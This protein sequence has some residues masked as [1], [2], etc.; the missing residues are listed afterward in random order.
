[1][2]RSF[3]G[4]SAE[5]D[6]ALAGEQLAHQIR[7][8]FDGLEP[9]AVVVFASSAHHPQRLLE[10]LRSGI[11]PDAALAGASSAGEF[12]QSQQAEGQVSVLALWSDEMSFSVGVGRQVR[13]SPAAAAGAVA[14]GFRGLRDTYFAYKTAMV[15]TDA[16]AGYADEVVE[17][18]T[19]ATAGGY[20]FFGG[21]A[22]D[23]GKFHQTHVF[24]DTEVL[25]DA[26][27][28]LEILSSKPIGIGV[29]HGWEAAGPGCRVTESDGMRIIGLN[30]LPAVQV[31][32]QHAMATGQSFRRE[33]P[34]PFL[35]HNILGIETPG[36]YRLRVPLAVEP[37]GTVACAAAVP[38]GAIVRVMKTS[39]ESAVRAAQ[40][41]AANAL[42]ALGGHRPAVGFVFDCVATRLRLGRSFENEL[43]AC[44]D[45]L[46][47]AQFVGCNTYGQIARADGQ[48]SGFHNCTAVVCVLPE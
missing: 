27:V 10:A 37:D 45:L 2:I 39:A 15:I 9:S 13:A 24:A 36:G 14:Q 38:Q 41:A 18:L 3:T 47:P 35:L 28:A 16:L 31:F 17:A 8:A 19:M 6:S 22:G 21:G 20:H 40:Q 25:T 46:A 12:T 43:K 42:A 1:M 48:F 30:G 44:A 29:S 34:L 4:M 7:Q 32:E 11:G 26:V 5:R 23:D 33:D